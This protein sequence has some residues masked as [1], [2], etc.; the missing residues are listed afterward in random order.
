MPGLI[1]ASYVF[2]I[3]DTIYLDY[4]DDKSNAATKQ[5]VWLVLT[6]FV[7]MILLTN[8]AD[9]WLN[10]NYVWQ[11][12]AIREKR[13]YYIY[14]FNQLLVVRGIEIFALACCVALNFTAPAQ[15]EH[16]AAV[17]W[18]SVVHFA[19]SASWSGS[20]AV[21]LSVPVLLWTLILTGSEL[22]RALEDSR[23][24]RVKRRLQSRS[25]RGQ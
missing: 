21:G 4:L 18:V 22:F 6:A 24:L 7:V 15:L 16:L 14:E 11:C 13:N 8:R 2:W 1:V 5:T 17:L 23:K 3:I 25:S 12:H 19:H 9:V 10:R 20:V